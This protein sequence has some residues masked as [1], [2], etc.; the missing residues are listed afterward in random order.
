M[1]SSKDERALNLFIGA[2]PLH[3]IRDQLGFTSVTTAQA[4]INRALGRRERGKDGKT[5]VHVEVERLDQMYRTLYPRAIQGEAK[6][7]EQCLKIS[8]QRL[9]L[10]TAQEEKQ[11]ALAAAYESTIQAIENLDPEG[12]DHAVVEAGR[13]VARQIDFAVKN[14]TGQEVTKAL[15]LLPHLM[16]VLKELGATPASRSALTAVAADEKNG[17][18]AGVTSLD[19][20]KAEIAAMSS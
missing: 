8:E 16:N 20:F 4:A 9:R 12:I 15:Y 18:P 3:K 10:I 5:L 14:G 6:A 19:A 17:A 7:I 11:G 13:A 1:T 2:V